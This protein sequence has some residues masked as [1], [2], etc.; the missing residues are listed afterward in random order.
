M[1]GTEMNSDIIKQLFEKELQQ[2]DNIKLKDLIINVLSNVDDSFFQIPTSTTGK[3]HPRQ[4]NQKHGLILHTKLATAYSLQLINAYYANDDS[5]AFHRDIIISALLLHD[6]G[7]KGKY[8]N[9]QKEYVNHPLT[10][11][12]IFLEKTE[13]G[14][15]FQGIDSDILLMITNCINFHMGIYSPPEIAKPISEFNLH[16][17]IVYTSDYL[18][19]QKNQDKNTWLN[20]QLE[21]IETTLRT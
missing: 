3:Y 15:M 2:I 17:L 12:K 8:K 16:E 7:K 9:Y 5:I 11:S 4:V 20:Q 14:T 1:R 10:A 19:T 13:A 21:R 18:A 6:I